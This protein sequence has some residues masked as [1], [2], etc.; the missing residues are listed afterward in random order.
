MKTKLSILSAAIAVAISANAVADIQPLSGDQFTVGGE[1]TVGG[2]YK[3]NKDKKDGFDA[4]N[5]ELSINASYANGGIVGYAEV[6]FLADYGVNADDDIKSDVDKAW[7][8]YD[9]GF[10]VLSYGLENDTALD[11]VDGA[12]DL[13][14]ENGVSAPEASDRFDVIKFQ[15]A[16][17]G[18]AYGIS[19]YN[20]SE[21]KKEDATGFNGY[22]G[23]QAD[24]FSVYAGYEKE[25]AFDDVA[26][27]NVKADDE[28]VISISGNVDLGVVQLGANYWKAEQYK[29]AGAGSD[30]LEDVDGYYVSAAKSFGA[31]DLAAGYSNTDKEV[32][33]DVKTYNVSAV[34]NVS[35]NTYVGADVVMADE[36]GADD[37][38][39]VY[40]KAG[41]IF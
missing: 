25:E 33:A 18:I 6:D 39:N 31:V 40:F 28:T 7:I 20:Q 21:E 12:G 30:N 23:Y 14:F 26:G 35:S 11:K 4:T 36:D 3:D 37:A 15:G 8:G 24:M 10:G 16:V 19:H 22:V 9:F 34:Y 27:K 38:T 17:N 13:T 32:S 29:A 41:Y 1:V 2:N 5:T